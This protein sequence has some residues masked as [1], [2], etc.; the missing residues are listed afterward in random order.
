MTIAAEAK[1]ASEQNGMLLRLHIEGCEKIAKDSRDQQR[2]W[3][4]GLG[5]R[6]DRQDR[7]MS[8]I[9]KIGIG[10]ASGTVA[11]L[12]SII[13]ALVTGLMHNSGVLH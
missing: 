6:L 9:K 11:V 13:G 8:G 7:E 5:Q 3:Q 1:G 12:L 2:E 4:V 10:I